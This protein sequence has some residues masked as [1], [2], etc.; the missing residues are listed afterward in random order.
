MTAA[1]LLRR[2]VGLL[3]AAEIPYMVTGSVAS[4]FHGTPRT[5]QDL[6][7][8][9]DPDARTLAAF[10]EAVD[11][12]G[13][14]VDEAA[15][16]GALARRSQFNVIEAASGWKADLV[17]R[18]DRPFSREEFRRRTPARVLGVDVSIATAEDMIIAKLEWASRSGSERQVADVAG[19]LRVRRGELDL[20]YVEQWV[21]V[22]GLTKLWQNAQAEAERS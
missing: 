14:Y 8:V 18:K 20:S 17:I 4:A 10:V 13:L 9:I 19:I 21:K 22:L 5:T 7:I 1:P 3:E 15:A 2:L 16:R 12:E 6:D 11:R